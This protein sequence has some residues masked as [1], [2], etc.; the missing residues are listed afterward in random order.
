MAK[1]STGDEERSP[2]RAERDVVDVVRDRAFLDALREEQVLIFE[3]VDTELL[4]LG[5]ESD[6]SPTQKR[7][8][9]I[10]ANMNELSA[11]LSFAFRAGNRLLAS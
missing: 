10:Q 6:D 9:D 4:D 2:R 1:S 11:Q 5:P 3:Q 8:R 7:L